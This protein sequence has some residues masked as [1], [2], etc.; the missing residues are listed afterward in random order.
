[1]SQ[2]LLEE[3]SFSFVPK[4]N[5]KVD[6]Y[7]HR[8]QMVYEPQDL[9]GITALRWIEIAGRSVCSI[10]HYC[11]QNWCSSYVTAHPR[12]IQSWTN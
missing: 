4:Y 8:S 10:Q 11:K 1:M 12:C 3:D 6:L 9:V 5:V 2:T 7:H